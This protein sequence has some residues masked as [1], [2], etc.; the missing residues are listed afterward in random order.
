MEDDILCYNLFMAIPKR[1]LGRTGCEVTILGLGG[2][3]ILRTFG[4]E[5]RAYRLINR[6][7]DSGITYCESARAYSGSE[8]YYGRS[9][10]ERR[11][12][13]FLASKSHA[14]DR[15]GALAQLQETLKNMRT[16]YLDLWQI[17]DVRT[18]DEREEIFGPK[19][20]LEAFV[21]AKE[22]GLARFIGVTGHHDPSLVRR[23]IQ[24]YDF[25]TVLIPVNPAEPKYKSFI[26]GVIPLATERDMGIVGMKV[27]L[28]GLASR[29]PWY[30]TMEPFFRFALSHPV[31]TAVVGCDTI[32]QLEENVGFAET[33]RAINDK[34]MQ[35]L[36]DAFS[37][38]ACELMYYKPSN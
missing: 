6:A 19:G 16:D 11:K 5:E 36:V 18:E 2:E 7:L 15:D 12:E 1:R 23:C 25:D 14:R 24:D 4:Y 30:R 28:R 35:G 26:D 34:E 29:L 31:S 22:K 3:G 8:G 32:E 20:A 38:Y 10:R 27:Y 17:H 21:E 33:F 37:P 13:I 9:L